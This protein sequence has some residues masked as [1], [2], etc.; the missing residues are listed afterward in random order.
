R[1]MSQFSRIPDGDNRAIDKLAS[2]K[3]NLI[4][5]TMVHR[6]AFAITVIGTLASLYADAPAIRDVLNN[7]SLIPDG[8]PNSGLAPSS[9]IVIRGSGLPAAGSS[10]T[11]LQD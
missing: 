7:S 1:I 4:G 6:I 3:H 8:F 9:L 2:S 10:A 5:V 11:P